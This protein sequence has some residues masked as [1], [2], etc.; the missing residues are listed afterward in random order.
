MMFVAYSTV[1]SCIATYIH[2]QRIKIDEFF[3]SFCERKLMRH[4]NCLVSVCAGKLMCNIHN[5]GQLDLGHSS[6]LH[7]EMSFC[8]CSYVSNV[9]IKENKFEYSKLFC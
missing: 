7:L 5:N 3:F 1:C 9:C 2:T 6:A 8:H 4:W